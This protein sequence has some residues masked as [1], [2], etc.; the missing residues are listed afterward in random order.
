MHYLDKAKEYK[1]MLDEYGITAYEYGRKFGIHCSSITSYTR[2]L[3]FSDKV[4]KVIREHT[5]GMDK[6]QYV[7]KLVGIVDDEVL[8]KIIR[9]AKHKKLKP[10]Q[11]RKLA[12]YELDKRGLLN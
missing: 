10:Y 2:Y 11:V 8:C 12:N 5:I 9:F 6:L 7:V 3:K 1:Q 4:Q